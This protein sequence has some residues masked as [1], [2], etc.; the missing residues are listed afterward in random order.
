MAGYTIEEGDKLRDASKPLP[1]SELVIIG[2][3]EYAVGF[4]GG[5]NEL[6]SALEGDDTY[7]DAQNVPPVRFKLMQWGAA[8]S[9][10]CDVKRRQIVWE[11]ESDSLTID[12]ADQLKEANARAYNKV[13]EQL[14]NAKIP[15]TIE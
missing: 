14:Q 12:L 5:G 2:V 13:E 10:A 1:E 8:C 3:D 4:G 11:K 15:H 7:E 9:H 6:I